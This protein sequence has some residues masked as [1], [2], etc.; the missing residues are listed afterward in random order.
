MEDFNQISVIFVKK[1]N[2]CTKFID[3]QGQNLAFCCSYQLAPQKNNFS[4]PVKIL[5]VQQLTLN[6]K[7]SKFQ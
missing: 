3:F 5:G 1:S 6:M 4:C 7:Y 2:F